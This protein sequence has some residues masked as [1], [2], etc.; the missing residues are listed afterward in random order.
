M[1][2]SHEIKT[3]GIV[4]GRFSAG[5]GSVRVQ[6][7]TE[8]LGLVVAI[9]KS[10]REERSKLRPFLTVGT[11][12]YFDLVRGAHALRVTGVTGAHNIY[13]LVSKY[14]EKQVVSARVL[15]LFRQLITGEERDEVLFMHMWRF[16]HAL[17]Y[18]PSEHLVQ[19]ERFV[20]LQILA[21][22]GYVSKAVVPDVGVDEYTDSLYMQLAT[23]ERDMQKAIREGLMASGLL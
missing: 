13:F 5:E 12:G 21:A 11:F 15:S 1:S 20:V 23:D 16:L 17:H 2:R 18:I 10:G 7:F 22:L 19:C 6:L 4:V 3:R 14:E 9:A 8:E